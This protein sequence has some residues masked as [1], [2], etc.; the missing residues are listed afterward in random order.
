[1]D[2]TGLRERDPPQAAQAHGWP[3]SKLIEAEAPHIVP[4]DRQGPDDPR[5]GLSFLS[6]A[7]L[8]CVNNSVRVKSIV[9]SIRSAG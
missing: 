5:D 6:A 9:S 8:S 3:R 2:R 4:V 1:V 7:S